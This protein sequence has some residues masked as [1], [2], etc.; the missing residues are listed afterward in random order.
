[1][2][3]ADVSLEEGLVT[4]GVS[5]DSRLTIAALRRTIRDQGFSPQAADVWVSGQLSE[6]NGTFELRVPGSEVTYSLVA[7]GEIL[8][9][10]RERSGHE[11]LL[12]GHIG[13]DEDG[14]TPTTLEVES[15]SSA[16]ER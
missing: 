8:T 10:L 4:V 14:T 13:Q 12:R 1:M 9:R 7:D 5:P 3:G 11:V 2:T 6:A 16:P 15:V